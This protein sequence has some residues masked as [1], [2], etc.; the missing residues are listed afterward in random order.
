MQLMFVS[1]ESWPPLS[2]CAHVSQTHAIVHHGSGVETAET[3]FCEGV[4][5]G[6][7]EEGSFSTSDNFFGSGGIA[8]G[9]KLL[10]TSSCAP[11]DRLHYISI[12]ATQFIS[13]SLVCLMSQTCSEIDPAYESFSEECFTVTA[14]IDDY[15]QTLQSSNGLVRMSVCRNLVCSGGSIRVTDKDLPQRRFVDFSAYK[16]FLRSS[17]SCIADNMQSS[18]R[19]R[20]Y[21]FMAGIS[22]GYDSPAIC[23]LARDYGLTKAFTFTRA[24]GND[25]EDDGSAI[26]A[27]LG[28]QVRQI[29]RYDWKK[30]EYPE[31][32]FVV[33]F[34]IPSAV[35]LAAAEDLLRQTVYLSGSFGDQIW[36]VAAKPE[37]IRRYKRKENSGLDISEF[38]LW[39]GF[40]HVPVPYIGYT[41]M[42]DI[43]RISK[44]AEMK[45]WDV[46]NTPY[47]HYSRPIA[48]RI[49]ENCGVPRTAFAHEKRAATYG[50][51]ETNLT[52]S[53]LKEVYAFNRVQS[54]RRAPSVLDRTWFLVV[55]ALCEPLLWLGRKSFRGSWRVKR[56]GQYL[57]RLRAYE[58]SFN[59][60]FPW[61]LGRAIDKYAGRE[62]RP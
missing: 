30:K 58:F 53:T 57:Q 18:A 42:D 54:R 10:L 12:G 6:P 52:K 4:W 41:G 32:P 26:G 13:N 27:R 56:A 62:L 51:F 44:S 60:C 28:I 39:K 15:A 19:Q 14:G 46:S 23:A 25:A 61:A 33:A 9:G 21:C 40:I 43:V 55:I 20:R 22:S 59:R 11:M 37:T 16:S 48:R 24:R 35:E 2:W 50:D 34:G 47:E 5:D 45:Q 7:F 38:R 8:Q 29:D 17:L 36:D 1:E 31:I 49:I 3:W